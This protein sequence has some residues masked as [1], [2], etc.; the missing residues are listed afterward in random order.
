MEAQNGGPK[1]KLKM[2]AQKG[3]PKME[4]PNG[5]PNGGS[6]LRPKMVAQNKIEAQN[7]CAELGLRNNFVMVLVKRLPGEKITHFRAG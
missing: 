4:A 3:R 7:G 5:G 6:K 1:L 2:K